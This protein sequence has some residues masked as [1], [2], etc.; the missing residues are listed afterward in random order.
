[1]TFCPTPLIPPD[2]GDIKKE[3][4]GRLKTPAAGMRRSGGLSP[5]YGL[6]Y[7]VERY[8]DILSNPL[9][10]PDLGEIKRIWGTPPNPRQRVI[11]LDFPIAINDSFYNRGNERAPRNCEG[12]F[13]IWSVV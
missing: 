4:R 13:V 5:P 11:P 12:L 1:M 9:D 8:D 6:H 2:L 7:T 3:D 10:P